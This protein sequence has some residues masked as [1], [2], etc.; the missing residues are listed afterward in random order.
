MSSLPPLSTH[1]QHPRSPQILQS[2]HQLQDIYFMASSLLLS[3][4]LEANQIQYH[5]NLLIT[6]AF[7]L[8]ASME[9]SAQNESIPVDWIKQSALQFTTLFRQLLEAEKEAEGR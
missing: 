7:P 8:L 9:M 3:Q 2:V 5:I 1:P 4:E 6:A